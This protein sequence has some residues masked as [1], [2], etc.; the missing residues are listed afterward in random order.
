MQSIV[1]VE[2]FLNVFDEFIVNKSSRNTGI[3][4]CC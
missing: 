1:V 2:D 4:F 3:K